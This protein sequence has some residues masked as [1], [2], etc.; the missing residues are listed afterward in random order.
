MKIYVVRLLLKMNRYEEK[1]FLE[2]NIDY[3]TL[4]VEATSKEKA[5]FEATKELINQNLWLLRNYFN[6][7][8]ITSYELLQYEITNRI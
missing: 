7:R 5:I 4:N 6:D 2:T 1:N 8:K 3:I